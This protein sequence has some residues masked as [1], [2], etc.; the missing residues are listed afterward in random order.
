MIS[1]CLDLLLHSPILIN[2]F[3]N[4][5][6]EILTKLDF[7]LNISDFNKDSFVMNS[8]YGN[9]FMVFS[10]DSYFTYSLKSFLKS[11]VMN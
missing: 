5:K 2:R 6:M 10:E 3:L 7:K 4:Q 9:L 8:N 1:V 11:H